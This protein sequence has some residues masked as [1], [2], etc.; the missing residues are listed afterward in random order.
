M[1]L[2]IKD[3][4][5]IVFSFFIFALFIGFIVFAFVYRSAY[6]GDHADLYTVAVNNVFAA[7][8]RRSN[9]E[10]TFDPEIYIIETDEYGRILFFYNECNMYSSE[11]DYGMAF[12]IMQSSDDAYVYYYPDKCYIPYFD[13]TNDWNTISTKLDSDYFDSLKK[14]NDWNMEPVKEKCAKVAITNKKPKGIMQPE[15]DAFDDLLYA[16]ER[17]IGYPGTDDN[18]Y[19][20]NVYCE[21]DRY[22]REL[23]YI[24]GVVKNTQKKNEDSNFAH[25]AII[26]NPDGSCSEKGIIKISSPKESETAVRT[27]K[28]LSGWN[29]QG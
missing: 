4:G 12:V 28:A 7:R 24:L 27:L 18:I 22:G 29:Q 23:H 8:G 3:I 10:V 6:R 1:K 13:I 21:T 11:I 5:I 9:G 26:L 16:F 17:R 15:D 14:D 25:Y 2:T 20:T 19:R